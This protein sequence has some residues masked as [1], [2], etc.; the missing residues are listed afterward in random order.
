MRVVIP[1]GVRHRAMTF[2]AL[3]IPVR[4]YRSVD[5]IQTPLSCILLRMHPYRDIL[6]DNFELHPPTK[7]TCLL[8]TSSYTFTKSK[9][10]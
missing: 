5:N 8:W 1:N 3:S 10:T 4:E 2:R 6:C 9:K 7:V